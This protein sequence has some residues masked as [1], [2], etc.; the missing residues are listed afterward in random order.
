[1][2]LTSQQFQLLRQVASAIIEAVESSG[3]AGAPAGVLYAALM[4]QGCT[5]IQF[6]GIMGGLVQAGFL[7]KDGDCY[8]STGR[9]FTPAMPQAPSPV[10]C[11]P[12]GNGVLL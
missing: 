4:G 6:D 2:K 3:H 12:V 11:A 8:F 1:M 7:R 10:G 5:L 9:E